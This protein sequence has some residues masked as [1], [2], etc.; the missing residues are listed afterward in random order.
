[1]PRGRRGEQAGTLSSYVEGRIL[2]AVCVYT[3]VRLLP[4]HP[5]V[6]LSYR[7]RS[8]LEVGPHLHRAYGGGA[9]RTGQGGEQGAGLGKAWSQR[10]SWGPASA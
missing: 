4:P 3:E 9:L 10:P 1:M 8:G 6:P 2:C 5:L 7:V